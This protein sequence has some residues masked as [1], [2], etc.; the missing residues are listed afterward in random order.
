MAVILLSESITAVQIAGGVCIAAGIL[1]A[2]RAPA[3]PAPAG[4]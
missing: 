1:A 3:V 4:E 2:R